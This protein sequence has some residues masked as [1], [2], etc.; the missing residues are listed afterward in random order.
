M[1]LIK[2]SSMTL[3]FI[4]L[5]SCEPEPIQEEYKILNQQNEIRAEGEENTTVDD[6]KG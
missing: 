3:F 6:S 5:N 1:R 4:L 2:F